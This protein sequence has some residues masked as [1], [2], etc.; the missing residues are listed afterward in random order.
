MGAVVFADVD[1]LGLDRGTLCAAALLCG[2]TCLLVAL[3]PAWR[4]TRATVNDTLKEGAGSLGDS[5][6]LGR[7]RNSF[8]VL[9]VALAV[10]LLLGAGLMLR[11]FQHLQDAGVGFDPTNKLAVEGWLPNGTSVQTF[12]DDAARFSEQLQRLPNVAQVAVCSGNPLLSA[13]GNSVRIESRPDLGKIMCSTSAISADYF[14]TVGIPLRAGRGF[15]GLKPGDPQVVVINETL[16][17]RC[18]PGENPLGKRLASDDKRMM[19]IIGVVG[20]VRDWEPQ[21]APAPHIYC[22]PWQLPEFATSLDLVIRLSG[23]AGL[24]F[25]AAVR[26]AAFQADPH[27]VV[28]RISKLEDDA[29]QRV[30]LER[31]AVDLLKAVSTLSVI[32]AAVGL[33]AVMAYAVAQRQREFGVRIALGAT[34]ENLQWFVLGRGLRLTMLGIALGLGAAWGLT[35]F[36]RTILY[37]T[38]PHDPITYVGVAVVLLGVAALACWLPARK[39]SM[40]NPI[41]ALR[42]E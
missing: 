39:A 10:I 14:S 29:Y 16:A 1:H 41:E 5:R 6:R 15:E 20:D 31:S 13:G 23:P 9:Q 4:V 30:Y 2:V 26:R 40:V 3:I 42:T 38:S 19:E 22:P 33:F 7:L 11:A 25:D 24:K 12:S 28:S 27:I 37:E 21:V 36:L 35:R 34:P 18:F 8:V 32:L 17:K